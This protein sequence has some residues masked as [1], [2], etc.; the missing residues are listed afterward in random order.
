MK[1]GILFQLSVMMCHEFFIW[2]AWYVT[3]ST[4]LA[5][6]LKADQVDIGEAYSAMAIATIFSPFFVGMIA[7]RFF[8]AQNV[9]G[10]LHLGAAVVLDFLTAVCDPDIFYWVLL[11]SSLMFAPHLAL[12]HSVSFGELLDTGNK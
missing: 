8:P 7:D 1:P 10:A 2:G 5:T 3:M 6:V 9:L 12:V 11:L 4:Y